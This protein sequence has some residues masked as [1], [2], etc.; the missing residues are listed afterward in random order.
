M[1]IIKFLILP[2]LTCCGKYAFSQNSLPEITVKN[3]NGKIIVSWLNDY[4]Q[5]I[6]NIFIQRSYDSLKNFSTIGSVLN[7]LNK[8][9]GYPDLNPP[10]NKMY[11]R[12][13]VS[14]EGGAYTIGPSTRPVKEI[15]VDIPAEEPELPAVPPK[16]IPV[17]PSNP[18]QK[19]PDSKPPAVTILPPAQYPWQLNQSID[20]SKIIP[21]KNEITYPSSRIY[22]GRQNN[23]VIQLPAAST[24]K[25]VVKFYTESE[26]FL[27][28]LT[29]LNEDY[30]IVEKVN[31]VQSGWF[32]FELFENGKMIEKNWFYIGKDAKSANK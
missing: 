1:R 31:F 4:T 3:I 13:S 16:N 10:Y 27:F 9:N 29:R 5:P 17:I 2:I 12:V 20:S 26:K 15:P 21:P 14:F 23:V 7:P 28:E 22:T 11:Y 18:P 8:E 25:Y 30:L 24:K 32:Y 6:S 19:I